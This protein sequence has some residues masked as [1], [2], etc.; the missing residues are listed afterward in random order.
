VTDKLRS[1]GAAMK[2]ICNVDRQEIGRWLNNRGENSHLPFRGRE[3]VIL[4]FRQMRNLQ[5][6]VAIHASD[7]NHFNSERSLYSRPDFKLNRT[8]A[9]AGGALSWRGA[10]LAWRKGQLYCPSRDEFELV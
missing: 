1:Y 10:K 5:K 6:F 7:Y 2:V 3:C 4:Y 9:L 8:A